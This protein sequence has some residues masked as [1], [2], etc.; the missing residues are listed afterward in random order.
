MNVCIGYMLKKDIVFQ[1]F[2]SNSVSIK[3]SV[4]IL[5]F[6]KERTYVYF[7]LCVSKSAKIINV[8]S[9]VLKQIELC[10]S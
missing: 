3:L 7:K 8:N 2:S 1:E 9:Y 10:S 4:N 5:T 6:K